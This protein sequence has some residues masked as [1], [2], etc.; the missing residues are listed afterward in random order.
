ME[1]AL[2]GEINVLVELSELVLSAPPVAVVVSEVATPLRPKALEPAIPDC[3]N[4]VTGLG[5]INVSL[6]S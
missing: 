2:C 3:G 6:K 5:G 1:R 4:A